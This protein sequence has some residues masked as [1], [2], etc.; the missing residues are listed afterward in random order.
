MRA[1]LISALGL[2][3]VGC[4]SE[5]AP[6][7]RA[8]EPAPEARAGPSATA[9]VLGPEEGERL[10][11]PDGRSALL[12]VTREGHGAERLLLG[13][14]S[15][16]PGTAI[17]VHSHDGYEEAL[18]VHEGR[19]R[20]TLG[21][22]TVQAGPGTTVYVP[23]GTWHGVAGGA[24]DSTTVLFVFPE[25]EIAG[26]FRAVGQADGEGAPRLS[27]EDWA[28]ILAQHRMRALTE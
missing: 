8:G 4:A 2:T 27:G 25:P 12:K 15:L 10:R 19:P 9:A 1:L 23:P 14:E 5:P 3:V 17:P 24:S 16:P 13:T 26:F 20:L 6:P 18:F 22:S 28:R 11:F 7:G 21:D